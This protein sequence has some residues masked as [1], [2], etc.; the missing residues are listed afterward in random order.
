MI[1][2]YDEEFISFCFNIFIIFFLFH[3]L[4]L[5]LQGKKVFAKESFAV[6]AFFCQNP[7]NFLSQKVHNL[8]TAKVFSAKL[9]TKK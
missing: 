7:Q 3:F 1:D 5:L 6:F 4:L 8:S 2:D 9:F